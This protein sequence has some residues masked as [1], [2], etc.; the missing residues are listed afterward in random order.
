MQ[1]WWDVSGGESD[2]SGDGVVIE[3]ME[4]AV[5]VAGVIVVIGVA[6]MVT[7]VIV[8]MLVMGGWPR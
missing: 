5:M 1:L 4:I 2:D 7:K 6:V 3:V 8:A